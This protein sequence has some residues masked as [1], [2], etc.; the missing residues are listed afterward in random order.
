MV[1]RRRPSSAEAGYTVGYGRPPVHSRFQP[2]QSGNPAGRRKGSHNLAADVKRTLQKPVK[3]KVKGRTRNSNTQASALLVLREKALAGD[4][5]AL[6]LFLELAQRFNNEP[7]AAAAQPLPA[8]DQ[9]ILDAYVATRAPAVM[10][11]A[12]SVSPANPTKR[13][14]VRS[15]KACSNE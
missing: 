7:E 5:R 3:L 12:A 13:S 14:R 1:K 15:R 10:T 9:A 4:I 6:H 8:D 11:T 2:G